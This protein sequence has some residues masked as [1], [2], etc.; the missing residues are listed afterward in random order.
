MGTPVWN[1]ALRQRKMVAEGADYW[2]RDKPKPPSAAA[3]QHIGGIE[4]CILR[5]AGAFLDQVMRDL[6]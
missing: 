6:S 4:H 5:P 3:D 1:C 2:M